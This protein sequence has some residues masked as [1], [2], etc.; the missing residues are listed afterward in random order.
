MGVV[1]FQAAPRRACGLNSQGWVVLYTW[2][3]QSFVFRNWSLVMF[4]IFV[5][6]LPI[7][8]HETCHFWEGEICE[9]VKSSIE[10]SRFLSQWPGRTLP[11]WC[12]HSSVDGPSESPGL[13]RPAPWLAIIPEALVNKE[14]S[15]RK[16]MQQL[17]PGGAGYMYKYKYI[18][19]YTYNICLIYQC[20]YIYI[21]TLS[22]R[23]I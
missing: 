21:C 13:P 12:Q 22:N 7:F 11:W 5:H 20:V 18:Y 6:P 4:I 16:T 23:Y 15:K 8:P 14:F 17:T 10:T 1:C 3:V 2:S 9:T 19:I